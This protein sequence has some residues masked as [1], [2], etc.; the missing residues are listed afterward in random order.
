[1]RRFHGKNKVIT[2]NDKFTAAANPFRVKFF[3]KL[4]N[5]THWL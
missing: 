5:F 2:T 4:V 1:M 3:R